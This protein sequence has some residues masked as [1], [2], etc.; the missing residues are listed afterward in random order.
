MSEKQMRRY[1]MLEKDYLKVP[2][3][4]LLGHKKFQKA[5]KPLRM[6][7]HGNCMEIVFL[8][9][10]TQDYYVED[11]VYSLVSGQAFV[12]FPNQTHGSGG[13]CQDVGEIYW[14]ILDLSC[15]EKFLGFNRELSLLTT[16]LLS[17]IPQHVIPFGSDVKK[18]WKAMYDEFYEK[19]STPLALSCLMH[20]LWLFLDYA[21][22][23]QSYSK[24]ISEVVNYIEKHI[25]DRIRI[26]TLCRLA[27]VSPSTLQNDFHNYCGRSPGEYINY[28][29][30]QRSK[31]MLL[32]GR[33]IT[34]TAM[35]LGFNTSDYYATVFRKFNGTSPSAWV[36]GQKNKL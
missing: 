34:E 9:Q 35:Q 22:E 14:M 36:K 18:I 1:G 7:N 20:L 12:S 25:E 8:T 17:A 26:D 27:D 6:H 2:G 19:G 29:K 13:I 15:Q 33:S 5:E 23:R 4:E 21:G 24:R 32:Q 11:T 16:D 28:R 30:I 3:L 10:G 31:E